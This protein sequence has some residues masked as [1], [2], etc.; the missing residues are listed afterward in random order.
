VM[1]P[2]IKKANDNSF[3][4][5]NFYTNDFVRYNQKGEKIYFRKTIDN[6]DLHDLKIDPPKRYLD[7]QNVQFNEVSVFSS[8]PKVKD[9][10]VID[11]HIHILTSSYKKKV[12]LADKVD[13]YG[14]DTGDYIFSYKIPESLLAFAI[15]NNTLAGITNEDYTLKIWSYSENFKDVAP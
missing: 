14:L 5:I 11:N 13:V 9:V 7:E 6:L 15:S 10:Q 1:Q 3:I 8:T 4:R 12:E 2:I